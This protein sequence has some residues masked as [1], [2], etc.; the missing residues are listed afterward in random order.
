MKKHI[1]LFVLIMALITV[2]LIYKGFEKNTLDVNYIALGDSVAIGQ[3]SYGDIGYGYSDY[4]SEYFAK[5]DRLD[6]Y[7]K[8][9]A[10]S[11]YTTEDIMED[12]EI[13]KTIEVDNETISIK[14]ALRESDLVTLSIG[15]N[16][17]LKGLSPSN[18]SSKFENLVES[19]KEIDEI[20][21]D[22]K[23]LVEEI[24]KYAKNK[25]VLVGYYNP[26][27]RLT[28]IK[29]ELDE[30]VK[31]SNNLYEDICDDLDI[32]CVDIFDIFEENTKY[33]PNPLD[34]HPNTQGYKEIADRIIKEIE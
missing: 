4:I 28:I 32:I 21:K 17:L 3:N 30:L 33:L 19:K 23:I 13:N 25:I 31:Y 15:A 27:P 8:G 34:I 18:F 2:F 14:E 6:F 12:I 1:K 10:K 7:T 29:E 16:N 5:N 9:F 11:G 24:K 26:F 22:V 20:V